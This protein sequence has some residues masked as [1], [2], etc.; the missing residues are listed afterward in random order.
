[1]WARD[2]GYI[3]AFLRVAMRR[4]LRSVARA[5]PNVV[6]EWDPRQAFQQG[7]FPRTLVA[8]NDEL[9]CISFGV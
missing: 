2:Y 9:R 3:D 1:M 7:R 8:D 4:Y 6:R 5:E